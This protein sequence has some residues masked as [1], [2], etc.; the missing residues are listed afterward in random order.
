MDGGTKP[1]LVVTDNLGGG[2]AYGIAGSGVIG[3]RALA[4][5]A[6]DGVF[7]GNVLAMPIRADE[8]PAAGNRYPSSL[9]DIGFQNPAGRDYRLAPSSRH[10][11]V[12][13]GGRNPGADV[14]AVLAATRDVAQR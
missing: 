14:A 9:G 6:P 13:S 10:R 4:L 3:A 2:G 12:A 8:M 11:G 7:A 1:R 5:H